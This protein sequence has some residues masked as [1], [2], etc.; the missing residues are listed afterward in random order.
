MF[1]FYLG[2]LLKLLTFSKWKKFPNFFQVNPT[3]NFF[4][5]TFCVSSSVLFCASL[6]RLFQLPSPCGS[7]NYSSDVCAFSR[8]PSTISC[9][10]RNKVI[11]TINPR[12]VPLPLILTYHYPLLQ[13]LSIKISVYILIL[14][15][16]LLL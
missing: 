14:C 1:S 5:C 11:V 13:S 2:I 6:Q 4:Q 10:T 16:S 15:L 8:L 12:T 3:P 7:S 9:K